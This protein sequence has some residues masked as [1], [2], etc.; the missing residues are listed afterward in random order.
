MANITIS[1]NQNL[2]NAGREYAQK[3]QTSLNAL[4]RNL[5]EQTVVAN[6]TDWINE[7]F[8]KMD[9]LHI[10]SKGSQWR[11]EDLYDI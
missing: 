11:R 5:L 6:S 10:D 3:H 7:C 8:E 2:L 4:I 1:M 9:K